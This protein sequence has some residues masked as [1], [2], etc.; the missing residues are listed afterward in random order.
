VQICVYGQRYTINLEE[1]EQCLQKLENIMQGWNV[2][3]STK[4]CLQLII[5]KKLAEFNVSYERLFHE[6]VARYEELQKT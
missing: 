6:T 3:T 4:L 2:Q 1:G 5:A